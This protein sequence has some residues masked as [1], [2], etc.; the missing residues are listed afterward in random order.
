M[1]PETLHMLVAGGAVAGALGF[2]IAFL[3]AVHRDYLDRAKTGVTFRRYLVWF[4][5][6]E[7]DPTGVV[8]AFIGLVLA[9]AAAAALLGTIYAGFE[10]MFR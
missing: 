7:V 2:A 5:R 4:A 3:Y 10:V 9:G 6:N 1:T 8:L